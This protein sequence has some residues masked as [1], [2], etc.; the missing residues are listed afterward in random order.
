MQNKLNMEKHEIEKMQNKVKG[1][2][3]TKIESSLNSE[4]VDLEKVS[5]LSKIYVR[6]DRGW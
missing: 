6:V 5:L 2:I 1:D 3:L 4:L